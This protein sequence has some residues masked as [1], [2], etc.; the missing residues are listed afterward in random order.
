MC[1]QTSPGGRL[2]C[3]NPV[4]NGRSHVWVHES[5]APDR[6]RDLDSRD[7]DLGAPRLQ[8]RAGR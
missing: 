1:R 6:K 7:D 8:A 3:A 2:A 4:C 5:S